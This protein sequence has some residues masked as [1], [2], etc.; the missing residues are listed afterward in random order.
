MTLQLQ[1]VILEQIARG[2]PLKIT[3]GSLCRAVEA[4]ATDAVCSVLAVDEGRLQTLAAPTLPDHFSMAINGLQVGPLVGSCGTA[5]FL[6]KPVVVT[7]IATDPRWQDFRDMA[8]PLGYRACWSSP[9]IIDEKVVGTFAFYFR[10]QRGPT[11]REQEIVDASVHLCALAIERDRR[12]AERERLSYTDWMTGLPNRL[13]FQQRLSDLT[14][15]ADGWGIL[16]LDLDNLKLVNDTFGHTAGDDLIR[17]VS[18]RL[19]SVVGSDDTFRLGGDEF[20]IVVTGAAETFDLKARAAEILGTLKKAADC[21]GHVVFPA[22]TIGGSRRDQAPSAEGVLKNADLALYHAKETRRGNFHEYASGLGT[23]ITRRFRAVRDTELALGEDRIRAFYQPI[24]RLDTREVVGFEALCRMQTHSGD[25]IS[26]AMFHEATKDAKIA[27]ELTQRMLL[28]VADDIS[29]WLDEG[30]PLQ[31]VGINISAVD[32]H[33]GNLGERLCDAFAAAHVPLDH[34]ILEVTE[35]VY[36]GR[37]ADEIAGQI[38]KLR[39][40]GLRVALDDFGTGYASLTHLLTMPVDI[41]KI[42][43]SFI[44]QLGPLEPACFIVEGLVQIAKKLGIRV[45]AEGI[46]DEAQVERLLSL[47]CLLGQ[48]FLFSKAVD[49]D[50]AAVLLGRYGQ[51]RPISDR[52]KRA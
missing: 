51:T 10:E 1:N 32:L 37:L 9:I 14:T 17:I 29:S 46:E 5:A 12:M 47:G 31:H 26:A 30:L 3:I 25:I 33:I 45:V 7:D 2:E 24:V 49:R 20:A 8:L 16:L 48:G 52:I 40:R 13:R 34:I 35:S 18:Q 39:E 50:T 21:A 23:A 19:S 43:K 41:I 11:L 28:Q 27:S 15:C 4:I 36:L 22:A 44:D 6:G 38:R 42:D